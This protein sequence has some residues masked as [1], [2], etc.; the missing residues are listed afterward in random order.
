MCIIERQVIK[1]VNKTKPHTAIFGL[2]SSLLTVL[3]KILEKLNIGLFYI[4]K[5]RVNGT[6]NAELEYKNTQPKLT[7]F[8]FKIQKVSGDSNPII[9]RGIVTKLL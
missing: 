4:R 2:S 7:I 9:R 8:F 3:G 1:T 5:T 6:K